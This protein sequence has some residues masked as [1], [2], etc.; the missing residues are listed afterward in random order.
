MHLPFLNFGA[1]SQPNSLHTHL[2]ETLYLQ[3][4]LARLSLNFQNPRLSR[5]TTLPCYM[6]PIE[7]DCP[8]SLKAY[9]HN[10]KELQR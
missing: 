10:L 7:P 1:K 8:L 2:V 4:T 6:S 9:F 3:H 5:L